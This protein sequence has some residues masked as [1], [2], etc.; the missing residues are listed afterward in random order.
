MFL[1]DFRQRGFRQQQ[2]AGHRNSILERPTHDLGWI[3]DA[4][5]GRCL[6]RFRQNLVE[7]TSD[8]G[9]IEIH[10]V[11]NQRATVTAGLAQH[12]RAGRQVIKRV[13]QLWFDQGPAFLDDQHGL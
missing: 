2:R 4:A 12:L 5:A 6:K 3:D 8:V 11:A 10:D 9:G 7:R 1:P 13:T